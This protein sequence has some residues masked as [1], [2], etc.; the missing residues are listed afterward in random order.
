M[1]VQGVDGLVSGLPTSEIIDSMI[2]AA[3][4]ATRITEQKKELYELRLES[5]RSLNTKLLSARLDT[6]A[7]KRPS[8][9]MSRAVSSSDT[10]VVNATASANA[11]PG[12]YALTV[13]NIA[14]PHQ[15]ATQGQASENQIIGSGDIV[16]QLGNGAQKTISIADASLQDMASAINAQDMGITASVINDGQASPYRLIIQSNKTGSE[17]AI[18]ISG[19]ADFSNIVDQVQMDEISEALDAEISFGSGAGAIT[20]NSSSNQLDDLI[21]GLTIDLVAA[22]SVN[23]NVST[24]TADA[25]TAITTFVESIN[26]AIEYFR[27]NSAYDS[28]NNE[29]GILFSEGGLRRSLDQLSRTMMN[30]VEGLPGEMQML[31]SIGVSINRTTGLFEIDTA[32]LQSALATNADGVKD[33][34]VNR[35]V[36][37]D[38]RIEFVAMT[39]KTNIDTPFAI[40]IT[41][42]A[43]RATV[44]SL[45]DL[46]TNTVITSANSDMTLMINEQSYTISLV[47]GSYTRSEMADYLEQVINDTV[48]SGGSK[49]E[50]TLNGDALNIQ[51]KFY[52]SRQSIS[53]ASSAA[54]STLNLSAVAATGTDVAGT[55][56]GNAATGT[57]QVLRGVEGGVS[58]GLRLLVTAN[59]PVSGITLSVYEGLGQR[60]SSSLDTLVDV[61]SGVV[62]MKEDS[63]TQNILDLGEQID[64]VN[65][66][67]EIRRRRLQAQFLQMEKLLAQFQGQERFLQGQIAGFQ[68]SSMARA[69]GR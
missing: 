62:T 57:G 2:D 63:L 69:T 66:R 17:S 54:Q 56:N 67:M 5:V 46:S 13:V 10:G 25:E 6:T 64:S 8:T 51:S 47:E 61:D 31:T 60:I 59:S 4:G 15:L 55:I 1:D 19:T 33:L 29:A 21:S 32:Q 44:A 37:S 58:E 18:T 34:F 52:G 40:D 45:G 42:A 9:Y 49:V 14:Q 27:A 38:S 16:L 22:G 23:I 30:P 36:S 39:G 28:E 3:S 12:S 7:L 41:T 26:S 50:V 11:V 20:V 65:E 68:N 43:S 35:G 48:E 53:I 24:E